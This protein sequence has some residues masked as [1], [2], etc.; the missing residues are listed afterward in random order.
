M[1]NGGHAQ[2][3]TGIVLNAAGSFVTGSTIKVNNGPSTGAN[4]HRY[5]RPSWPNP[6]LKV[7][8]LLAPVTQLELKVAVTSPLMLLRQ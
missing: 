6:L 5:R 1:T 2:A 3:S 7:T 4:G 8:T